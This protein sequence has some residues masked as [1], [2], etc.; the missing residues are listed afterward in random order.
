MTA[1]LGK[2]TFL[3]EKHIGS[4]LRMARR[5]AGLTQKELAAKINISYQ[6]V[7]KYENGTNRI[8]AGK[9]YLFAGAL[10]L[11]PHSFFDGLPGPD[12]IFEPA[13]TVEDLQDAL[14]SMPSPKV[15]EALVELIDAI[16]RSNIHKSRIH[17]QA[18]AIKKPD[19]TH[20][21]TRLGIRA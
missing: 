12:L 11:P 19:I 9:L 3:L 8:S 13:T 14:G 10:D 20:S 2:K 4:N 16:S 17:K 6:Q 1:D 18:S 5:R 7:Q 21:D 15:R